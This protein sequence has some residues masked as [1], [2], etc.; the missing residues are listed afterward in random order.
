MKRHTHLTSEQRH[1]ISNSLKA[2]YSQ[3]AI[4]NMIG[5]NQSTISREIRRN[6]TSR[7]PVRRRTAGAGTYRLVQP[8]CTSR[9]WRAE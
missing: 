8:G 6:G 1:L 7:R 4:A 3:P 2:G 5:V 9:P